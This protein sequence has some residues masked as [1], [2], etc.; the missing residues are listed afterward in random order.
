M[1]PQVLHY[2]VITVHTND[3]L[4]NSFFWRLLLATI[5]WIFPC[6]FKFFSKQVLIM[7]SAIMNLKKHLISSYVLNGMW[8][9]V[10]LKSIVGWWSYEAL[11]CNS[12]ACIFWP[13][14]VLGVA[15][16]PKSY[17]HF[18][19][20][21]KLLYLFIL[22]I[23][24]QQVVFSVLAT[25][26]CTHLCWCAILISLFQIWYRRFFFLFQIFSWRHQLSTPWV[27][28]MWCNIEAHPWSKKC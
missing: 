5:Y 13:K 8:A 10:Y 19:M 3:F 15:S 12:D 28:K 27:W 14:W 18:S 26:E 16:G 20:Q 11:S 9:C 1:S 2:G 23:L 21:A 22:L 25:V 24:I 4:R 17:F 6:D 7:W